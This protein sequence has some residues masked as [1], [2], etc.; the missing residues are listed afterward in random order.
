MVTEAKDMEEL[1]NGRAER[2]PGKRKAMT[3]K[4]VNY[5]MYPGGGGAYILSPVWLCAL[6]I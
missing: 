2:N 1:K 3:T 6:C 4:G 5:E